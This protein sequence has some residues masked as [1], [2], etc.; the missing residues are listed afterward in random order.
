MLFSLFLLSIFFD[1]PHFLLLP[2]CERGSAKLPEKRGE[3]RK[4]N[5]S[6]EKGVG[7]DMWK[8]NHANACSQ[9]FSSSSSLEEFSIFMEFYGQEGPGLGENNADCMSSF[10]HTWD[11]E[12]KKFEEMAEDRVREGEIFLQRKQ[13]LKAGI[14]P[15]AES[16]ASPLSQSSDILKEEEKA[17]KFQHDTVDH[18]DWWSAGVIE[19]FC[20]SAKPVMEQEMKTFLRAQTN[21]TR[22]AFEFEGSRSHC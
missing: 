17:H 10:T 6:W 8:R 19:S 18:T 15:S 11:R 9:Y 16:G 21:E 13:K 5:K 7:D 1:S 20:L 12:R 2:V 3:L 22:L 14:V 4:R